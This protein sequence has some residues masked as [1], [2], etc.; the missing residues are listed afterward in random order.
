VTK[1][2]RGRRVPGGQFSSMSDRLLG[3]S[4]REEPRSTGNR[5]G[6]L[7]FLTLPTA[8]QSRA[9]AVPILDGLPSPFRHVTGVA[10]GC[11]DKRGPEYGG[12]TMT[13]LVID[14]VLFS[15]MFAF[16]TGI[17]IAAANFLI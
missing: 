1:M 15:C 7:P 10:C 11:G 6:A 3:A 17:M 8:A 13:R 5:P 2:W 14:V 9:P 4:G 16:V 12:R